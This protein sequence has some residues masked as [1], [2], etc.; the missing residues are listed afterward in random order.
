MVLHCEKF[1]DSNVRTLRGFEPVINFW[2]CLDALRAS[3]LGLIIGLDVKQN[4][5]NDLIY[6]VY[7]HMVWISDC[8][9][10]CYSLT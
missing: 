7:F 3:D 2:G 5:C 4:Q 6:I 9:T 10:S 1:L 8:R